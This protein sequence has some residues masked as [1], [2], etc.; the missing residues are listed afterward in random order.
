MRLIDRICFSWVIV[1]FALML[2]AAAADKHIGDPESS[3]PGDGPDSSHSGSGWTQFRG[4]NRS[5]VSQETGLRRSWPEGG[6]PVL[7]RRPLGEG[8]SGIVVSGDHLYTLFAVGDETF[9]GSFRVAD[10]TEIWRVRIG[11]KF[12]D[13][14][15]N[16]P[17]S[18]P[19]IDGSY[20]YF[21]TT[22]GMLFAL[23]S[24][25][26]R[27]IW[28]LDI[29]ERFGKVS[30]SYDLTP[31]L[32]PD[33]HVIIGQFGHACSPLV[34]GNL[35]IV[36]TGAGD[37][38]SLVALDKHTGEIRWTACDHG[39]S[40]TSPVVVSIAGQRQIVMSLPGEIVSVGTS[41]EVLWRYSWASVV[42]A[43]PVFVPPNRIFVSTVYDVGA[44]LLEV[45]AGRDP[46]YVEP[47]WQSRLMRNT[48]SS[49]VSYDESIFGFDNATLRCLAAK[50]GELHWAKRGFG[51]GTLLIADG[52][53]ILLSDRGVL[54]LAEAAAKGYHEIGRVEV[55]DGPT[56]TMPSLAQ[57][58]LFLRN[59]EEMVC[60]GLR[61]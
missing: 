48:W 54:A 55:L 19:T 24:E 20:L 58:K 49:S 29:S 25:D 10:G 34:E 3:L 6:P 44:M 4:P 28:R 9:A 1:H 26:G 23:H 45:Q 38:E 27:V 46:V 42:V 35:V 41:G 22:R 40:Y 57:G 18:T 61:D 32:P 21:L 59:H 39:V 33:E 11:D 50:T 12:L 14:W 8:F 13:E 16:G 52:L 5:G 60:L 2:P 36:Y 31:F 53:L 51:K 7:W 30:P 15:G 37:E 47:R 56:W 17:R 43:Q